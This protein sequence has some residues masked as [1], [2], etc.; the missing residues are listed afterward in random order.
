MRTN[1]MPFKNILIAAFAVV[2]LAQCSEKD[3]APGQELP[4]AESAGSMTISG[5]YTTYEE[6]KD[7]KTCTFVVSENTTIVDGEE[8]GLEAGA[9]ICLDRAK[10][11]GDIEFV[12]LVGTEKL[13]VLIGHTLFQ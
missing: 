6:I 8:L 5:V 3:V 2:A 13:P 12:N 9:I 10:Q 7:C 11:Y 4:L 1:L